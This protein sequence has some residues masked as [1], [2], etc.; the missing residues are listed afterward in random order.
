M[1]LRSKVRKFVLKS[2]CVE[3]VEFLEVN[4]MDIKLLK[5]VAELISHYFF[6]KSPATSE[7]LERCLYNWSISS[8]HFCQIPFL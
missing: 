1:F 5:A 4:T 7:G 6:S 2:V 3:K 8:L